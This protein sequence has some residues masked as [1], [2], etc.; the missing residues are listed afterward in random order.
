MSME[1]PF[2]QAC[3]NNKYPILQVLK[4]YLETDV[5]SSTNNALLEV[6]SGTGQ[7]SVYMSEHLPHILW[8]PSDLEQNLAGIELWINEAQLPNLLSPL[9]FDV[10]RNDRLPPQCNHLFSA[11]T[12]HIMS[13]HMVL[14]LFNLI[15]HLIKPKGFAFFYGPF[16]YNGAF[17]TPS[18]ANFDA[19]L[20]Q[21][22]PEQGIRDIEAIQQ[23]AQQAGLAFLN[24]VAMP[25]N[26]QMLVFQMQ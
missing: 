25:A 23:L 19:W 24:D 1:K 4:Q 2:S 3:E 20:K 21:R 13:W 11:N 22:A 9:E 12:L 26:N 7:H 6:G 10:M 17:T 5:I 16:K 18:N 15:P 14:A 8:Q